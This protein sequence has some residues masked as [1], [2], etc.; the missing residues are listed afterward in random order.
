M[1]SD[2]PPPP[3][4]DRAHPIR[5]GGAERPY[6]A[7]V[8]N[9]LA[10]STFAALVIGGGAVPTGPQDD[11]P[12]SR[13]PSGAAAPKGRLAR[14]RR[15]DVAVLIIDVQERFLAEMH[16]PQ[17]P[18]VARL[19]Q[20]LLFADVWNLP[21]VATFEHPA[22]ADPR[23]PGALGGALPAG[24]TSLVKRRFGAHDEPEIAA[25]LRATGRRQIVVAGCETD[26]CVLQTVLGLLAAGYETFVLE[27]AV[28]SHEPN[29]GPA[30]RRMEAAGAIPTTFK[31]F[32]FEY[33]ASVSPDDFTPAR[34]ARVAAL[35]ERVR[36]PY[37]LP[38]SSAR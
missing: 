26:V 17:E 12:A 13:V 21:V 29:V 9:L 37:A 11:G 10:A 31:S 1:T 23:L 3:R 7:P 2:D 19:E 35:R 14:L 38:P 32:Y 15:E 8:K 27:D 33:E 24:A 34:R 5:D 30:L 6:D 28:F 22:G 16:G 36:S 20:L 25:A 18:V 4:R